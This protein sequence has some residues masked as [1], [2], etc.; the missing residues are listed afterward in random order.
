MY[1]AALEPSYLFP[2]PAVW[3]LAY[4]LRGEKQV[5]CDG[6]RDFTAASPM[7]NHDCDCVA[8]RM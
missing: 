5:S 8:R 3:H 1:A 6:C 4:I 2:P 7:L